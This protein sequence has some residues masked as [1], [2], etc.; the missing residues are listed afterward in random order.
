MIFLWL[1]IIVHFLA[2]LT[3]E[4]DLMLR[5]PSI[6][7]FSTELSTDFVDN[8]TKTLKSDNNSH[9][10]IVTSSVAISIIYCKH[11]LKVQ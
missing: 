5:A 8:L 6:G 1:L 10:K 2:N 9:Q 7:S 4:P 3:F 11:E